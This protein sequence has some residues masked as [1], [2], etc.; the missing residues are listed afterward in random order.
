MDFRLTRKKRAEYEKEKEGFEKRLN[1]ELLKSDKT[2]TKI[3]IEMWQNFDDLSLMI[4]NL[5]GKMNFKEIQGLSVIDFYK[6]K[7]WLH[8][9]QKKRT[10]NISADE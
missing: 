4:S 6:L 3:L 9:Q 8:R 7:T 1:D 10:T 2:I 5:E